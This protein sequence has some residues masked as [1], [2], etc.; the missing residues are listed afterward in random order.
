TTLAAQRLKAEGKPVSIQQIALLPAL[1]FFKSYVLKLGILDGLA[2]LYVSY[3][4]AY[5]VFLKYA[6]RWEDQRN[7]Q[8]SEVAK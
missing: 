1:T 5:Y 4:A 2:G 8:N 3:F 6:K 7:E